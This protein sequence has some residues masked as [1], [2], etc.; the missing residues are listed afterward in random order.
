MSESNSTDARSTISWHG[1]LLTS[2]KVTALRLPKRAISVSLL[3]V[4][5]LMVF[6][7]S[8]SQ[9][10]ASASASSDVNS[11][12]AQV[13]ASQVQ[14]VG[15]QQYASSF[16]GAEYLP[17]GNVTIFVS[18]I[19]PLFQQEVA[20]LDTGNYQFSFV[21]VPLNVTQLQAK[22]VDVAKGFQRF[23]NFG[24][25]PVEFNPDPATGQ[26]DVWLS[27]PTS[28]DLSQLGSALATASGNGSAIPE[29]T[30]ETYLV[31]ANQ[32]IGGVFGGAVKLQSTFGK[33]MVKASSRSNDSQPWTGGDGI[34][35]PYNCTSGFAVKGNASG[36]TF[37]LTAGHCTAGAWYTGTSNGFIGSTSTGGIHYLDGTGH[38]YQTILTGG[39]AL[40]R[41]WYANTSYHPIR[42]YLIP[43]VGTQVTFDG[44][45]TGEVPY[46]N[47]TANNAVV[48]IYENGVYLGFLLYQVK[49]TTT[50][51]PI[52]QVGDSGGP[53][54]QRI[55]GTSSVY[56][57]A[58]MDTCLVDPNGVLTGTA[59]SGERIDEVM[60]A[61][62]S[63]LIL[64]G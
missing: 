17:T 36:N 29:L 37:I 33:E 19:D 44:S 61:S 56:A 57:V 62:N 51:T 50:T 52:C 23:Q 47:V 9:H 53:I 55:A 15:Q 48:D 6:E 3:A 45:V 40:G 58:V 39:G 24:L 10:I 28:N 54:Y 7:T 16:A 20:I 13:F 11:T 30:Q 4:A 41:V 27:S 31:A 46:N 8:T 64:G 14:T 1:T 59:G 60:S 32:L 63:S 22:A 5:L 42:N 18:N 34:R 49:A 12:D 43:A 35:G 2:M 26:I 21:V 25:H 38:D